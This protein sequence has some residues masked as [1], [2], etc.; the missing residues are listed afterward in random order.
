[1]AVNKLDITMMEDVGTSASQLL[2]RDGSGNIP[3]VDGSQ[4][5]GIDP[6]FTVST[7][8]PVVTTNPSGGVGSIWYNKTSGEMYICTDAT[9]GANVWTNVGAGIGD[10]NPFS[11]PQ[12][13]IAAYHSGGYG[14]GIGNGDTIDI[15]DRVSFTSDGNATDNSNLSQRTAYCAGT[16]SETYGYTCGGNTYPG[17]PSWYDRIHK[18]QFGTTN[19]ATDIAN[20][21]AARYQP[22]GTMSS[23]YGH[24]HGG[25][26]ASSYINVIDKFPY[27]SDAN[28]TDH[29]DLTSNRSISSSCSS[30]TYGYCVGGQ[31]ATSTTTN[32][33]EKYAFASNTTASDVGDLSAARDNMSGSM[34]TTYGYTHGGAHPYLNTIDR[35]AFASDG[36]AADW[37]D[38]SYNIA[39]TAGASAANHGYVMAGYASGNQNYIEKYPYATQTNAS[40]VGDLTTIRYGGSGSHY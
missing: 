7:S 18:F 30:L 6:G 17:S 29:G 10:V 37:A 31:V 4:L 35:F 40:D 36:N 27:A 33:I 22:A 2:Q 23:T 11:F 25:D 5:T 14:S 3:A 9:A 34:S 24:V 39:Y 32:I 15:I 13:G 12:G 1:M 38:I 21:S 20:L 28:A 26:I 16:S 8:D 19:N